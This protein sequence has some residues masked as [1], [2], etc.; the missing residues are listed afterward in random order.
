MEILPRDTPTLAEASL[1][2]IEILFSVIAL[3]ALAILD[4]T[5][6]SSLAVDALLV[7]LDASCGVNQWYVS[8]RH[9]QLASLAL[10]AACRGLRTMRLRIVEES[11]GII[12]LADAPSS[13]AAQAGLDR[14]SR[15]P[16]V[17]AMG[18]AWEVPSAELLSEGLSLAGLETLE[19]GG[20]FD[21]T[22]D[23]VEWPVG[24]RKLVLGGYFNRG[25]QGTRFPPRL[26]EIVFGDEFNCSVSD[27]AWPRGLRRLQ[28]G[29]RFNR[30]VQDVAW[31]ASLREL[32][33]GA[34]FN[35]PLGGIQ[36]ASSLS[37]LTLGWAFDQGIDTVAWPDTL[38]E[39]E[40]GDRFNHGIGLVA[41]PASL[42]A[43]RFGRF[44][45][46][47]LD[48]LPASIR[49]LTLGEGYNQPLREVAWPESLEDLSVLTSPRDY[50]YSLLWVS[51]PRGLKLLTVRQGT[52]LDAGTL[53]R[54]AE[55]RRVP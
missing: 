33:F 42:R 49:K 43:I 23:R 19:F 27:V 48:G 53:P 39:L 21:D 44:F 3:P 32:R 54:G 41:W 37:R 20:K 31:P 16:P 51:W 24:L 29:S 5:N 28:F 22:L 25:L 30:P 38:R 34:Y 13:S 36:R 8:I 12:S 9:L 52:R 1:K 7:A 35:K 55:V 26:E 6:L 47:P 2:Q 50:V 10:C 45:S 14:R 17:R 11:L 15:V 40:F 18:W 4:R 46:Q